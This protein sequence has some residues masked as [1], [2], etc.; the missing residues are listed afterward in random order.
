MD[1]ITREVSIY[2]RSRQIEAGQT[3]MFEG[4]IEE[5]EDEVDFSNIFNDGDAPEETIEMRATGTLTEK[6]GRIELSYDET[7]LT[8]MEGSTTVLSF[9]KGV[10]GVLTMIRYGAVSTA[11]IFEEGKRHICA[12]DTKIMPFEICIHTKRVHNHLTM[13]GGS[14]ELDYLVEIHG[15]KAERTLFS[16]EVAPIG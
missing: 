8:G 7:E 5:F 10:P 1:A 15:A 16:L 4:V 6:E 13:D 3:A 14:V 11:L 9:Q 2:L 12:Y